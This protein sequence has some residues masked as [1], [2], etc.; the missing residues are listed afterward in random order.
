MLFNYQLLSPLFLVHDKI[1]VSLLSQ[2]SLRIL[3]SA[4]EIQI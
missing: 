1:L 4:V 3:Y 2:T